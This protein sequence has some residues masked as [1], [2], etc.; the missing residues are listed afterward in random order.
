M[1][2]ALG[3]YRRALRSLRLLPTSHQTHFR[4]KMRY[5]FREIADIV[6]N[7][8]VDFQRHFIARCARDVSTLERVFA[9]HSS[10][11]ILFPVFEP[12]ASKESSL[13]ES[14][15]GELSPRCASQ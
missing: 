12:P 4:A 11:P 6:M 2:E 1:N 14:S 13:S 3:L 15:S 9:D 7:S 5:N 8:P 10:L